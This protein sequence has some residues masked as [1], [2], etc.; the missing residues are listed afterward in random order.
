MIVIVPFFHPLIF[1]IKSSRNH[2]KHSFI[3]LV[4][5]LFFWNYV[6]DIFSHIYIKFELGL[7]MKDFVIRA[8]P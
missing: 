7:V 5:I 6:W 8:F 2:S 3:V 1:I 4:A